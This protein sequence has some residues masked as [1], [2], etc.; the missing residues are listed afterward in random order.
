MSEKDKDVLL[1]LDFQRKESLCPAVQA[2]RWSREASGVHGIE[3]YLDPEFKN[4]GGRGGLFDGRNRM[5]MSWWQENLG[6]PGEEQ[7]EPDGTEAEELWHKNWN[8]RQA[9][10]TRPWR[11]PKEMARYSKDGWE[12]H[13]TLAQLFNWFASLSPVIRGKRLF[14]SLKVIIIV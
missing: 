11:R 6:V 5:S 9:P 2:E 3:G 1:Q 8:D 14:C 13:R 7:S 10:D 4:W 12:P